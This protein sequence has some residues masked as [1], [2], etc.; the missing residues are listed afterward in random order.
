MIG[1]DWVA[2]GILVVAYIVSTIRTVPLRARH[3]VFAIACFLIAGWRL[4]MGAAG[5]NL[6]FVGVAVVLGVVYAVQAL[7]APKS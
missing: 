5:V 2:V 1:I 7:R 4:R 6:L 3:W